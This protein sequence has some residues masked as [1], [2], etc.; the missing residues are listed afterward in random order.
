[1][2]DIRNV[3]IRPIIDAILELQLSV[4]S[5]FFFPLSYPSLFSKSIPSPLHDRSFA[6]APFC[7]PRLP[8]AF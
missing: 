4:V 5:F 3:E 1:M 2:Q 7:P 8:I 6:I